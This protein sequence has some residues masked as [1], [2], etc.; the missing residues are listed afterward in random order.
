[1]NN[2]NIPGWLN[3]MRTTYKVRMSYEVD[4]PEVLNTVKPGDRVTAKVYE[5]DFKRYEFML[6]PPEDM[7]VFFPKK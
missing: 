6:A 7:P 1:V 5:G 3:S 2:E 4:N